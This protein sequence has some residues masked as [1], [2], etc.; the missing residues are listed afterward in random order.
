MIVTSFTNI[1]DFGVMVTFH[2]TNKEGKHLRYDFANRR[3]NE[4]TKITMDTLKSV[5]DLVYNAGLKKKFL[6]KTVK[7]W[8]TIKAESL[9]Y[10][11]ERLERPYILNI[12]IKL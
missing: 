12:E 8:S 3:W 5:K 2:A 7:N 6:C 9:R 1:A 4:D 11:E 10:V